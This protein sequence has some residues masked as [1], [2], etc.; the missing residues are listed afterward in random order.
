M[1]LSELS[2]VVYK[3]QDTVLLFCEDHVLDMLYRYREFKDLELDYGLLPFIRNP[4]FVFVLHASDIKLH[5]LHT[6][7]QEVWLMRT[8]FQQRLKRQTSSLGHKHWME[9]ILEAAGYCELRLWHP[10]VY[11]RHKR[12]KKLSF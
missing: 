5:R 8:R 4:W 1:S 3:G 6:L 2:N 10:V 7:L 9:N 11:R 12:K